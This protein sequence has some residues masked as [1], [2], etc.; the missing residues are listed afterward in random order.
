M[1][2]GRAVF[3]CAIARRRHGQAARGVTSE[4]P[5]DPGGCGNLI[6]VKHFDCVVTAQAG[7]INPAHDGPSGYVANCNTHLA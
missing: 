7:K 1:A 3:W 5:V 2:E 6:T 4:D